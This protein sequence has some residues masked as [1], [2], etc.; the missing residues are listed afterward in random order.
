MTRIPF[1][2]GTANG[3]RAAALCLLAAAGA[4]AAFPDHAALA[5]GPLR[6]RPLPGQDGVVFSMYGTPG[7]LG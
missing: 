4:A 5:G 7:D 3:M 2:A 1:P 6:V